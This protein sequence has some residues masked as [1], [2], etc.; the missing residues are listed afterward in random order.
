MRFYTRGTLTSKRIPRL[1]KI[2]NLYLD[3]LRSLKKEKSLSFD[4]HRREGG[5]K[6]IHCSAHNA[7]LFV[8]LL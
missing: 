3:W 2:P 5:G 1:A 8:D 7:V 4:L 6:D